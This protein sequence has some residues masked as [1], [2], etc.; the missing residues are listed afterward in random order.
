MII[1]LT[2][3]KSCRV[4]AR[5]SAFSFRG[6][7][8]DVRE[9]GRRLNVDTVL[10]GT[11]HRVGDRLRVTTQ[12]TDVFAVQDEITLAIIKQLKVELMAK[13]RSALL[14]KKKKVWRRTTC[15]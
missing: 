10:D 1:A 6:Q 13:E 5:A 12:L 9:I 8:L 2:R 7:D 15:I 3:I 4:V 11:V 14:P